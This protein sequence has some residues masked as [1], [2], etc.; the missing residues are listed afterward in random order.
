[1]YLGCLLLFVACILTNAS[2]TRY[3][4]NIVVSVIPSEE[5]HY[6]L[7]TNLEDQHEIDIWNELRR[8]D[9][10]HVMFHKQKQSQLWPLFESFNMKPSILINDVQKLVDAEERT[11]QTHARSSQPRGI[12]D[13][14]L[15]YDEYT[16]WLNDIVA[17]YPDLATLVSIGKTYGNRDIWLVKL[18]ANSGAVKKTA[19]MDF[20]IHAREWISPA[21][22][23]YM[24]NEYLTQYAAG[25]SAKDILDKWELHIVP[26][27]N[28]DGYA[29]SHST[30][31]MWRKNRKPTS[32]SCIGVDLNR[33]F[34]YKWN[35]GGSS[36]DPCSETFHG[37]APM[38]ENEAKAVQG[39]MTPR[40]WDTYLT[41]HS[42]G[43][44]WFTNWGYTTSDP[45]QYKLLKDKATI[46][47]NAL[48]SVNGRRYTLGS[49][50]QL[51]Y[52]AS[53]GSEDWTAGILGILYSYCLELPPTGGSG[54]IAPVSEIK[55][56]GAETHAGIVALLK[57]L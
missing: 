16:A 47:I 15:N 17:T 51:L 24:I 18:T 38:T 50:A 22:G 48:Q 53:G 49:S 25:G 27:L 5:R 36:S 54:F 45:P 55:K 57:V 13:T 21:T 7:L 26:I 19:F 34:G 37:G 46:G 40:N 3:D 35:T 33:N 31:R 32:T 8:N 39:Y 20:G 43:Q 12:L 52:V 1:M 4:G 41:F 11:L 44:W 29:Y 30:S 42:Y 9:S 23:G 14:F 10:V 6:K 56:T 2:K 28:P